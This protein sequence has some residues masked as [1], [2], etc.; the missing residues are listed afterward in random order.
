MKKGKG[1][2]YKNN[3]SNNATIAYSTMAPLSKWNK[4]MFVKQFE[5]YFDTDAENDEMSKIIK[6]TSVSKL[7]NLIEY[8]EWHHVGIFKRVTDFYGLKCDL[9]L[10]EVKEMISDDD[11]EDAEFLAYQKQSFTEGVIAFL[12]HCADK[13]KDE[14][15]EN[16]E[17]YSGWKKEIYLAEVEKF[18]A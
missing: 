11:D 16:S 15:I 14:L 12:G 17:K 9:T 10:D 4:A 1:W 2:D 5:C 6:S 18:F 7:K 8:R 13:T 3:R